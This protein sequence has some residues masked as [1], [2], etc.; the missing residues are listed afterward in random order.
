MRTPVVMMMT[1]VAA[2]GPL[3][4]GEQTSHTYTGCTVPSIPMPSP[5]S[6]RPAYSM[7]ASWAM[8]NTH[9]PVILGTTDSNTAPGNR[10]QTIIDMNCYMTKLTLSPDP[11]CQ[12]AAHDGA[13]DLADGDEADN[14]RDLGDPD[15]DPD[16]G[17]GL[18]PL[19]PRRDIL[20]LRDQDR[21]VA[22]PKANG[23]LT[24]VEGTHNK[25]LGMCC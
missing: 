22:D 10:H 16:P 6:T 1:P 5:H 13:P 9:Q 2:R 11:R 4:P 19:T 8:A 14:P 24:K 25:T 7:G 18:T 3:V 21:A 20:Q 12:E 15:W 17:L 23:Q